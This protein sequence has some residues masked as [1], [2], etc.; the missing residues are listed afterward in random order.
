MPQVPADAIKGTLSALGPEV[1]LPAV[2]KTP[3]SAAAQWPVG[4][5]SVYALRAVVCYFGHHYMVF[6]L[7][8]ELQLW[9]A[10]D[11]T[12]ISLVGR[13]ED[14]CRTMLQKRLQPSLL[15]YESRE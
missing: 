9:L 3:A 4:R 11:D 12:N 14:V 8:E 7:S 10:I 5:G 6:A 2:F 13:W 15:F 1:E